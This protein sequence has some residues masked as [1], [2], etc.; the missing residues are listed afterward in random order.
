MRA[1]CVLCF[2]LPSCFFV[3]VCGGACVLT[4][5]HAHRK[6]GALAIHCVRL[7]ATKWNG[8]MYYYI[9]MPRCIN[10]VVFISIYYPFAVAMRRARA[11]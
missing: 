10:D 4:M 3:I 8:I 7:V 11:L 6:Q 9:I 5:C 2:V 1:A